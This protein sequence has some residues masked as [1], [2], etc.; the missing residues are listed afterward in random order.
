MPTVGSVG[1]E[2]QT[3]NEPAK[4]ITG[5]VEE[6]EWL[7]SMLEGGFS[8]GLLFS[9]TAWSE[10]ED[11]FRGREAS[12]W[13]FRLKSTEG[14]SVVPAEKTT[15]FRRAY[16]DS[17]RFVQRG[18]AGSFLIRGADVR[19]VMAQNV[20]VRAYPQSTISEIVE[21][22]ATSYGLLPDVD[23]TQGRRDRFQLYEDDWTHIKRLS[24]EAATASN[25]GDIYLWC[26]DTRLRLKAP[27]LSAP[28]SRLHDLSEVENR[29]DK[30]TVS[31]NGRQ[32]DRKG[33]ATLLGI[34]YDFRKG[35]SIPVTF[36]A[37]AAA[38]LPA[39]ARQVPRPVAGGSRTFTSPEEDR[40][41][42][43]EGVASTWMRAATRYFTLRLDTRPDLTLKPGA[44]VEVQSALDSDTTLPIFG[45]YCVLEV[46]HKLEKGYITTTA[47]GFR[48]EIES[49]EEDAT[50]A[51]VSAT[52]VRDSYRLGQPDLQQT[53]VRAQVLP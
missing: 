34:G 7:D 17:S 36:D 35:E 53:V 52:G 27:V 21:E 31:Y 14:D 9:A 8:W 16:V 12:S 23:D 41:N 26:D 42:V 44:I 38:A 47:V 11:L 1:V 49:G 19:L 24:L 46:K 29:I 4:D 13:R 18:E 43:L 40:K 39:L 3:D 37:S 51:N 20:H 28:S 48:R 10:W 15:D 2:L 22:I 30:V 45:R 5:F 6:F 25:R 50:G 32:V 33:G